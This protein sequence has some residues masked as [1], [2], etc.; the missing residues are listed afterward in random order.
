MSNVKCMAL[1]W[2]AAK[3]LRPCAVA[4]DIRL[5]R[6]AGE[7]NNPLRTQLLMLCSPHRLKLERHG[8]IETK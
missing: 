7:K 8:R 3:G 4:R 6:W 2:S 1:V 5:K